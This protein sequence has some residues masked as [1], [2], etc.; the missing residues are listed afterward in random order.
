MPL[1][2]QD[3]A[4]RWKLYTGSERS[5]AQ[6]HFI[7]LCELLGQPTPAAHDSTGERY[8]FEKHVTKTSGGKGFADVWLRDHFA[9][10]Y[11]GDHKDLRRA[12]KQLNDYRE[13]LG[14]PPLL[15]VSDFVHF[16][17]HTNFTSTSKR[18]YAFTLDD[19]QRNQP[20]ATCP[21]PPLTVLR[22]LF[23]DTGLLRPDR[24]DAQI[25]QDAATQ[26]TRIA[27]RLELEERNLGATREQ[28]A[29]FLMRILFCLF[30]DSIGL[31]PNK[32]FRNLLQSEDRFQPKRFLRKL[33]LLFE[34]MS[35]PDGIFG[36][37]TIRWF[38]GGLFDSAS[39]IQLD[40]QDLAIL[41][42]VS[43]NYDWSHIAPAIF[44]T[45]FERS[46]IGLSAFRTEALHLA[47]RLIW[48]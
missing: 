43:R 40:R 13:A 41:Y 26:F 25:T 33:T 18:V 16:E 29:H 6:P 27:E 12:Y 45:L 3:F 32:V 5:G 1:A 9:W 35:Q 17:I 31:L 4:H 30:A 42:E 46:L 36:E 8:A 39:I 28:I 24:T 19:L 23:G 14:N 2:V 38:N 21:L 44:G 15:V 48:L 7:D 22:A 47:P 11:K 10:E 20:T 34:A 37:H